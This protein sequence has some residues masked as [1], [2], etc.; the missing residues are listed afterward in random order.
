MLLG[1]NRAKRAHVLPGSRDR[2]VRIDQRPTA[3]GIGQSGAPIDTWTVLVQNMPASREDLF[4]NETFGSNQ[5]SARIDTRWEINYRLDM[6]PEWVDVTKLRRIVH[7]GRIHD[8]IGAAVV[9]RNEGIELVTIT[10][11]A[12]VNA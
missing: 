1:R 3:D 12:T 9:G 4:A 11:T 10:S 7:N 5:L 2:I 6:D 8:I